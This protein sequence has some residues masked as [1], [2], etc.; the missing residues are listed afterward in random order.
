MRLALCSL[1]IMILAAIGW[2]AWPPS[3]G[4]MP[5][6]AAPTATRT[7]E[8]AVTATAD[9][10]LAR[11][12]VSASDALQSLTGEV[13]DD[14]RR[15]VS[16]ATVR[17]FASPE[18]G[19]AP[20]IEVRSD[21]DGHF[22]I[23]RNVAWPAELAITVEANGHVPQR[24]DHVTEPHLLFEL[25][26]R[27]VLRG[28]V[29]AEGTNAPVAGA[30]VA[31]GET[32]VTTDPTGRYEVTAALVRGAA[33]LHASHAGYVSRHR[34]ILLHGREPT[35]VDFVLPPETNI[36]VTVVD[37]H[38]R[39]PIVGVELRYPYEK[40][41]VPL[42]TDD[43][44][45]CSLVTGEGQLLLRE[46]HAAGYART[47]WQW[48]VRDVASAAPLIPMLR[49]ATI[50]G[51]VTDTV[52]NPLEGANVAG[53]QHGPAA[54]RGAP[55]APGVAWG[56]G[57]FSYEVGD[58]AAFADAKGH[59]TLVLLP[60]T[61]GQILTARHADFVTT[62]SS[63][64]VVTGGQRAWVELALARGAT[65]HGTVR[66]NGEQLSSFQVV[67][68]STSEPGLQGR[69]S[70]HSAEGYTLRGIAPGESTIQLVE[71][72]RGTVQRCTVQLEA[73]Q[74]LQH[75]F[76]WEEK[77]TTITGKITSTDGSPLENIAVQASS[78]GET[79]RHSKSVISRAD[80]SYSIACIEGRT[81]R[82]SARRVVWK[83]LDGVPA[84]AADVNFVLPELGLLRIQLLDAATRDPVRATDDTGTVSWREGGQGAWLNAN[85]KIDATGLFEMR[86]PI[87]AVDVS[88]WLTEGGYQAR[89]LQALPV[90]A[91]ADP[92]PIPVELVR[93]ARVELVLA[94]DTPMPRDIAQ[95]HLL[96]FVDERTS[97]LVRGPF[98]KQGGES[99][100]RLNGINMWFGNPGLLHRH[101]HFTTAGDP[102]ALRGLAPGRHWLRAFPDD[103]VFEP[104][105]FDVT[106]S[107]GRF[108]V[109]WQRR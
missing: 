13:R 79:D 80:G 91:N 29:L 89:T 74:T 67:W 106:E 84:G 86:L 22:R 9:A 41:L 101:V 93:G 6:A 60:S 72:G 102:V 52:G 92:A 87:G 62:T 107:G 39:E 66:R 5:A 4:G 35:E 68:N 70:V 3:E 103:L 7:P 27:V 85:D 59:F 40:P 26:R 76:A 98:A 97:A 94:G 81:Y 105:S 95:K 90:T 88:M 109:R 45:R 99:N 34:S 25:S 69:T 12:P 16:G 46:V 50:E 73:G 104:A 11:E 75:D 65:L 38:T 8:P 100:H 21:A 14:A 58:S 15:P 96:F 47:T 24:R 30:V 53:P 17:V 37:A 33:Q 55:D 61:E 2:F 23:E 19:A 64:V 36:T 71:P 78:E 54:R 51:R 83:F 1:A 63:P 20:A 42:L 18:P 57:A 82:V 56:P 77:T 31:G 44:G 28:R 10:V 48:Q 32:A 49:L 108:V 43:R